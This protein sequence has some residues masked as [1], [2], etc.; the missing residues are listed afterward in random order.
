VAKLPFTL[1]SILRAKEDY[2]EN[3]KYFT[4]QK[5]NLQK[6][7]LKRKPKILQDVITL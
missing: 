4:M 6:N 3:S 5:Y 1:K 7:H 2:S